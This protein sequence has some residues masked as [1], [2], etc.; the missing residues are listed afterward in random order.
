VSLRELEKRLQKEP[1]NLGLKVQVAGLLREAGRNAEAVE[2]YRQVAIAYRDGG[3]KQQAIAVCKSILELA[4][5]DA[6]SLGLLAELTTPP[7]PVRSPTEPAPRLTPDLPADPVPSR[8]AQM[9]I[10]TPVPRPPVV[11]PEANTPPPEPKR[12][13]SLDETPL[14]K[15]VPYHVVDPTS[16]QQRLSP[17]ALID[18]EPTRPDA[19]QKTRED[20]AAEL[21]TRPVRK[22]DSSEIRKISQPIPTV[23]YPRVDFDD[24]SRTPVRDSDEITRP[25]DK[26]P[27]KD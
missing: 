27:E 1:G 24:D 14:P 8:P 13:S 7:A 4:P 23:E 12:R 19:A 15:P 6:A 25:H 20:V 11:P 10:P 18:A 16:G 5:H 17:S 26:L 2:L 3:R 21:D 9:K 22:L